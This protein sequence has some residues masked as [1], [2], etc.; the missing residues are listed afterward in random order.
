MS[1]RTRNSVAVSIHFIQQNLLIMYYCQLINVSS[2]EKYK[3]KLISMIPHLPHQW[4]QVVTVTQHTRCQYSVPLTAWQAGSPVSQGYL[5]PYFLSTHHW[6]GV[7]MVDYLPTWNLFSWRIREG[8][9]ISSFC[10]MQR[11][12]DSLGNGELLKDFNHTGNSDL[13]HRR[14]STLVQW[15]ERWP[16]PKDM[17]TSNSWNLWMW[18]Y[19]EKVFADAIKLRILKWVHPRLSGLT[20]NLMKSVLIRDRKKVQTFSYKRNKLWESNI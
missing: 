12:P 14:N 19:L 1:H 11:S 16:S 18:S 9:D 7:S 17:S 13:C 8:S 20:L 3:C 15:V 4:I 5:L 6:N 10:D 2:D